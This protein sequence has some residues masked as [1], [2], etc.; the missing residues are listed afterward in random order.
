MPRSP[1]DWATR[2][3]RPP[4]RPPTLLMSSH[5][6]LRMPAGT[7]AQLSPD[8]LCPPPPPR[9]SARPVPRRARAQ[10][11]GPLTTPAL[12]SPRA[13]N[14]LTRKAGEA[15]RLATKPDAGTSTALCGQPESGRQTALRPPLC[16]C[17]RPDMRTTL[18]APGAA[19]M[20]AWPASPCGERGA[21]PHPTDWRPELV[22][23]ARP[24]SPYSAPATQAKTETAPGPSPPLERN[25]GHNTIFQ[26]AGNPIALGLHNCCS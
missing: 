18:C 19:L 11:T 12:S 15:L 13:R 20:L 4:A 26:Q 17:L 14:L 24:F 21:T 8:K 22:W 9:D 6:P 2:G 1:G 16:L 23:G 5:L 7:P 3:C 25:C 10:A